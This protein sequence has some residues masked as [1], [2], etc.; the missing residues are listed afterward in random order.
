MR[1][2]DVQ[3]VATLVLCA[4]LAACGGGQESTPQPAQPA[5]PPAEARA[6]DL[7]IIASAVN[8]MRLPEQVSKSYGIA[9]GAQTWLLMVSV[10]Q[11]APEGSDAGDK[12][13]PAQVTA[14]ARDLQGRTIDIPMR[15]QRTAADYVDNLGTFAITPPDTLKFT[16][17]VTPQG[18]G[19]PTTLEFTREIAP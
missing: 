2:I 17:Q 6:G 19:G 7:R 14:Q 4:V 9:R 10:R 5:P 8:T 13:W 3:R 12:S 11:D 1:T 18:A 15:E 16:V